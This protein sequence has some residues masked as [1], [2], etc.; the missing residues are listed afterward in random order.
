VGLEIRKIT[1]FSAFFQQMTDD[2]LENTNCV[3]LTMRQPHR[4]FAANS[5]G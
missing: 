4:Q 2:V 3:L 5:V 1:E